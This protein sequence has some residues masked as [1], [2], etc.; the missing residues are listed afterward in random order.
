MQNYNLFIYISIINLFF[1]Q[2]PTFYKFRLWKGFHVWKTGLSWRKYKGAQAAL[3][4]S[5]YILDVHLA[6]AILALRKRLFNLTNDSF[7]DMTY[8]ENIPFF[9]FIEDQVKNDLQIL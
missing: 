6:K 2:I 9:Y 8:I 5:L 1:Q 3:Q 7:V 4:N